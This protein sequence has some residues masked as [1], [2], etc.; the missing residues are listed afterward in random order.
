MGELLYNALIAPLGEMYFQ[1][2]LIGGS[3]VAVVSG[4]LGCLI[5][6][7]RMSFLGDALAHAMIAGVAGGY[8]FIQGFSR[9]QY[10]RGG[11]EIL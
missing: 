2:A 9:R 3:V 1:K 6:L 10:G 8:L 4:V 11:E 7:R 5:I